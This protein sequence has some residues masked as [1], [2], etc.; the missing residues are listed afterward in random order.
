MKSTQENDYVLHLQYRNG[1][2]ENALAEM[3]VEMKR[4]WDAD[5]KCTAGMSK[6]W[7]N[8]NTILYGKYL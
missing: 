6:A 2:L 7:A 3:L 4:G 1:Q 8:A 5:V